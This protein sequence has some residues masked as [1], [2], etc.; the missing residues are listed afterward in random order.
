MDCCKID[1]SKFFRFKEEWDNFAS[2]TVFIIFLPLLPLLLEYLASGGTVQAASVTLVASFFTLALGSSSKSKFFFSFSVLIGVTY[3]AFYPIV[4]LKKGYYIV[5]SKSAWYVIIF[6]VIFHISERYLRHIEEGDPFFNW[7]YGKEEIRE[8][9]L[10][11]NKLEKDLGDLKKEGNSYKDRRKEKIKQY[12]QDDT[13]EIDEIDECIRDVQ[14]NRELLQ[15]YIEKLKGEL[16][17]LETPV[18]L[19]K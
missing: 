1:Y 15:R 4:L 6:A 12:D 13:E 5:M 7:W 14:K 11:L 18:P 9:K 17:N 16:R 19:K 2:A 10:L 8:K 3:A